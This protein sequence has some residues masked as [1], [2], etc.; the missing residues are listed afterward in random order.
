MWKWS[1]TVRGYRRFSYGLGI[2]N[3]PD[4]IQM[5][6]DALRES[7]VTNI[8]FRLLDF[9]KYADSLIPESFDFVFSQR[10][11]TDS[12]ST[13][14]AALRVL[15]T[16]GLIFAEGIGNLHLQEVS[17]LFEP[18]PE[19]D[20][21]WTIEKIREEIERSGVEIRI[22]ADII[23]KWYYP[24]L[25]EWLQFQCDIWTWLGQM[26]PDP[27]D[28][29]LQLFAERNTTPSGEIETTHHLMW[30]GGLKR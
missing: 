30:I 26:L 24:D 10:G 11:P 4:H 22:A 21:T 8:E 18:S 6:E 25:Y 12:R 17:Q 2:D 15:R 7:G 13:I 29:R 3:D 20:R 16:D 19:A 23:S 14:H 27:D 1:H 5:A 9:G 28:P